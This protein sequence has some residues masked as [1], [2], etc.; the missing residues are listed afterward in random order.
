M[1]NV[2]VRPI[3]ESEIKVVFELVKNTLQISYHNVYPVEAIN[4]FEEYHSFEHM[5]K[6]SVNGYT[7]VAV[8]NNNIV[9]TGTLVDNNIRRVFIRQEYQKRGVGKI[10]ARELEKKAINNMHGRISLSASPI[11][12]EFWESL[13][14][15]VEK[16]EYGIVKNGKIL[17]YYDMGKELI[18][19]DTH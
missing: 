17:E 1:Q 15:K 19:G 10:I 2:I 7:V 18:I 13:G 6:D 11:S 5:L 16:H 3:E 9:G 4:Y 8:F 12:R 14:F